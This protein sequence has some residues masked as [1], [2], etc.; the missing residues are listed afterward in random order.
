LEQ[1]PKD[2]FQS[3]TEVKLALAGDQEAATGGLSAPV[4]PVRKFVGKRTKML[5]AAVCLFSTFLV[6]RTF[7]I[8]GPVVAKLHDDAVQCLAFSPNGRMLASGSEDRSIVLSEATTLRKLRTLAGHTR[9]VTAVA[10]SKNGRWLVSGSADKSI[11][12]WEVDTGRSITLVD[13]MG[14]VAVALSPDGRWLASASNEN[15]KLWDVW[16]R[17]VAHV[18]KHDDAVTALDF[19][20]DGRFL[21]SASHDEKV[22]IWEVESGHLSVGSLRQHVATVNVVA[23]SYE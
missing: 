3:A 6:A 12:L 23:L 2:R 11:R 4:N 15:I 14:V 9:A 1:N 7:V 13:E 16:T 20:A 8:P 10:F 19:S 17:S 21:A 18:L 22:R 5:V